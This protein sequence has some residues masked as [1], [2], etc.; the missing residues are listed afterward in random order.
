MTE[1][2]ERIIVRHLE[3]GVFEGLKKEDLPAQ[4]CS[5][6]SG[7]LRAEANRPPGW[8]DVI[9]SHYWLSGQVGFVASERWDVPLIHSM[10]HLG[11]GEEPSISRGRYTRTSA[12]SPW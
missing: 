2:D 7:V 3:S 10:P 8:Y 12:T 11:Q 5:L 9:H 1:L 6:S 4:L